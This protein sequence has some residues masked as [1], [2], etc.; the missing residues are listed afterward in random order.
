MVVLS[1][2]YPIDAPITHRTRHIPL[3]ARPMDFIYFCFFASHLTASLVIDLQWLYPRSLVP[4]P[5]RALLEYYIKFS[6]DP[7]IGALA[8]MKDSSSL[9]W[10]KTFITLEGIFQIPVFIVGLG[11]LWHGCKKIYPL[12]LIYA[13]SSATT[14]LPCIIYLFSLPRPIAQTTIFEHAITYEQL[15]ILLL[16]YVSFFIVPFI[17]VFDFGNRVYKLILKGLEAEDQK[18]D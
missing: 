9:T 10:F 15:M 5:M 18:L 7:L 14:T 3:T 2:K 17:M 8:G 13:A 12:L 6:N 4:G 1:E 16:G 11:A